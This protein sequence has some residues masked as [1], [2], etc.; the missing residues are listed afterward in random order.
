MMEGI[1]LMDDLCFVSLPFQPVKEMSTPFYFST[2][3]LGEYMSNLF[4]SPYYMGINTLHSFRKYTEEECKEFEKKFDFIRK[5]KI[6]Y[7]RDYIVDFVEVIRRLYESKDICIISKPTSVCVCGRIEITQSEFNRF[8]ED[9]L[10]MQLEKNSEGR[11][12]CP[13]CKSELKFKN[14][15]SLYLCFKEHELNQEVNIYPHYLNSDFNHFR[16]SLLGGQLRVS[17]VRD[18]GVSI[19]LNNSVFNLDI[20]MLWKFIPLFYDEQQVVVLATVKHLFPL[21]IINYLAQI[22]NRKNVCFAGLPFIE[23]VGVKSNIL[24]FFRDERHEKALKLLVLLGIGWSKKNIRLQDSTCK[25]FMS[26]HIKN[27]KLYDFIFNISYDTTQWDEMCKII[28]SHT[29]LQK[30]LKLQN[31]K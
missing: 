13:Y 31:K 14:C 28:T 6:Y 5:K 11:L 16:K 26:S 4:D 25:Y 29:Q 18:T 22:I 10:E 15:E 27:D 17:R 1:I 19:V 30:V 7:D 24:D 9:S 12:I 3:I 2:S 8:N 21:F 20:D 23:T